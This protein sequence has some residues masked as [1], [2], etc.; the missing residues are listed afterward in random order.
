MEMGLQESAKSAVEA[1]FGVA[2]LSATAV[3]KE[4]ELGT[5]RSPRWSRSTSPASSSRCATPAVA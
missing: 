4:L 2:F 1:G 3:T 5:L